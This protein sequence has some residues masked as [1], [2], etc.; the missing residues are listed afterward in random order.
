M[1]LWLSS[2]LLTLLLSGCISQQPIYRPV[3]VKLKPEPEP[4]PVVIQAKPKKTHQFKEVQDNN[5]SPEYMYPKVPKN[6]P[7]TQKEESVSTVSASMSREDCIAMIGQQKFDKYTQMLGGE[8]AAVKRCIL[9]KSM[10]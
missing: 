1:K 2:S 7:K 8:S 9:L 10:K 4:A 3:P 5:F 6:Q